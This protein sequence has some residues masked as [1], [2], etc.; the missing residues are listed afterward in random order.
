MESDILILAA[1]LEAALGELGRRGLTPR[2]Q[3]AEANA[4][5]IGLARSL[6]MTEFQTLTHFTSVP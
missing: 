4:A 2:Y 5:S 3:V 6:G 1:E